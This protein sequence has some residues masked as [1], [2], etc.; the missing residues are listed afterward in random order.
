VKHKLPLV[1][2]VTLAVILASLGPALGQTADPTSP[3]SRPTT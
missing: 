2:L 1:L 3:R